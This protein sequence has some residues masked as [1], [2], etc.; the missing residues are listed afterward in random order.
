LWAAHQC[1]RLALLV[2]FLSAQTDQLTNSHILRF[3]CA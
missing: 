3:P 2:D 1:R